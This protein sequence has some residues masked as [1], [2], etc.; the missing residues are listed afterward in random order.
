[1]DGDD[2]PQAADIVETED[3]LLVSI[4]F[5]MLEDMHDVIPFEDRLLLAG[6]IRLLPREYGSFWLLVYQD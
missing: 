2:G 1:M 3:D 4:E 6:R 5:R